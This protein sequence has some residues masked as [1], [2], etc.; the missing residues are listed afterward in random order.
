MFANGVESAGNQE[1]TRPGSAVKSEAS[2]ACATGTVGLLAASGVV[3]FNDP[4]YA[5]QA[6]LAWGVMGVWLLCAVLMGVVALWA[7]RDRKNPD[8]SLADLLPQRMFGW[9]ILIVA[10]CAGSFL[11][12]LPL[13]LL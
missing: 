13:E 6:T 8:L 2:I 9:I 5:P 12:P 11:I 10:V 3:F 4:H 7:E 1:R